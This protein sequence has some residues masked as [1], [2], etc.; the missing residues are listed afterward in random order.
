MV[1]QLNEVFQDRFGATGRIVGVDPYGGHDP[2]MALGDPDG[3]AGCLRVDAHHHTSFDPGFPGAV[4]YLPAV[5]LV[6]FIVQ[7]AVAVE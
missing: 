5:V 2:G 6:S 7:M 3:L 4:Q 1:R